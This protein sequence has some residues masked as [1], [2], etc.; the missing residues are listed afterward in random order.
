METDE[1]FD[2]RPDWDSW[3]M[4][5]CCVAATR[6]PDISTAHGA[7]ICDNSHRP[8]GTG[9]NGFPRN[10]DDSVFPLTRPRK[11]SITIHAEEN[12]LL[13]SENLLVGSDYTMYV[14]GLPCPRCFIKIM[15]YDI[16]RV[17]YG[18]VSSHCVDEKQSELTF[19]LAAMRK[20]QLDLFQSF[21]CR[22]NIDAFKGLLTD[23]Q[24]N[25]EE[26]RQ[27]ENHVK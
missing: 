21:D 2:S 12:C 1:T 11:Y 23:R 3:V 22:K 18:N 17:V 15:Q 4:G 27:Q 14:T 7:V 5:M 9:Y 19:E 16:R 24:D 20:I 13:N 8:K 26:I 25:R 10:C 6:S